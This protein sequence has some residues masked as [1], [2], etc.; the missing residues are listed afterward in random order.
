MGQSPAV[1]AQSVWSGEVRLMGAGIMAVAGLRTIGRL[2]PVI[3]ASIREA[4]V[5]SRLQRPREER[6]L[7]GFIIAAVIGGVH[8]AARGP[9]SLG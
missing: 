1:A 9:V 3:V 2:A 6:E 5:S 8:R 7:P 4:A